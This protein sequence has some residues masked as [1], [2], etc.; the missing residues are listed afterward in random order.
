MIR[1][2]TLA[3]VSSIGQLEQNI[4]RAFPTTTKRQH[5]T[6]PVQITNV[7]YIPYVGTK[8]LHV[9]SLANNDGNTYKQALQ[10]VNVEFQPADSPDNVTILATDN[11]EYS[12]AKIQ[13]EGN[14]AKVRCSCP[15]FRWRFAN[16]NFGDK[17]L[18]GSPPPKYTRKTDTRP[19]VNPDRVPGLCKHLI[20]L[21]QTLEQSGLTT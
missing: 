15:D 3:E 14:L 2:T 11:Q 18:V 10:F 21:V 19:P 1:L 6:G 9:R 4:E 5:A 7:E 8:M 12:L 20:K 16:W 13:L 17:S